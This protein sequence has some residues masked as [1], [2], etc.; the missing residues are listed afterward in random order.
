MRHLSKARSGLIGISVIGLCFPL[1]AAAQDD[2]P[3]QDD[4]EVARLRTQVDALQDREGRYLERLEILEARLAAMENA[5]APPISAIGA[6]EAAN[7]RGTYIEPLPISPSDDPALAF[8]RNQGQTA[9]LVQQQE[10]DPLTTGTGEEDRRTPAPTEA[11]VEI[12]EEQQ[13]RFGSQIGLDLGL[14]YSHFDNA[15]ISLNGFLALDAIFL[16]TISIDQVTSDIYTFD[17]TLR[18]GLSDRLFVDA[19]LPY[20]YRTS[21]FRSGGAG[22]SASALVEETVSDDGIG[23]LNFGVSYRLAAESSRRPDIV[24][25]ARLKLP[26]GRDPYG[27]EFIEVAN[28]E[29]NLEVPASLA[30]GSGVYGASV[31]ASVLKTIDPLVVFGSATYFHNFSR[32]F[33]DIDEN[34]GDI[35]GRVDVGDAWQLGAGLAFALNDRSSIS[36]S[37]SQRI[38]NRTY[39]HPDGEDERPVVGSQANVGIV[40]LG[41]TFSL[42]ERL[43]LIT[44]VGIGLT[45][46]SPNM[47]LSVR[48]PYRF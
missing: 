10:P 9:A 16:G 8:F 28:S 34:E 46:D 32:H 19:N 33:S 5:G 38:V 47:S 22:G 12:A 48:I 7:L 36:M 11:V 24:L 43:A 20:L 45:N 29:G 41:A 21:N 1:G 4:S 15:R 26:T 27:V 2:R 40:N 44:N 14:G 30:T 17:P 35:P 39:L 37:Y 31:G 3:V 6:D 23:D 18:F 25:N 42:G 13:G